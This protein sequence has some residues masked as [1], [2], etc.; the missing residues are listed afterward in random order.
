M[1]TAVVRCCVFN[2]FWAESCRVYAFSG[3][4][5]VTFFIQRLQTFFILV[6]FFTFLNVFYSFLNVFHI[7]AAWCTAP[8]YN[9]LHTKCSE[10][11]NPID[12]HK[13][14]RE[15]DI[16]SLVVVKSDAHMIMN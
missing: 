7:Y 6:T 10:T 12:Q 5:L 14:T 4:S 8:L 16:T 9:S 13:Q 2:L 1:M 3:I 11:Q 15:Q